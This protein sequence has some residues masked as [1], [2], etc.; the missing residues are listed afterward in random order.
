M[1]AYTVTEHMSDEE[2][3]DAL[4]ELRVANQEHGVAPFEVQCP[5]CWKYQYSSEHCEVCQNTN[6]V[7][8]AFSEVW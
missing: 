3:Q 7:P 5:K 1:S 2:F 4:E 6:R 8:I